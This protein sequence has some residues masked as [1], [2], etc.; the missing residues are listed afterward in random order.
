MNRHLD[1]YTGV[2]DT[3]QIR[4][5]TAVCMAKAQTTNEIEV[6]GVWL[7]LAKE[8]QLLA[9]KCREEQCTER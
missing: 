7:T 6:K 9:E 8:W 4:L 3:D 1:D 2:F 5:M